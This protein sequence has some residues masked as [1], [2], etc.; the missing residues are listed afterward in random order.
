VDADTGK[1]DNERE[2]IG[3]HCG[4]NEGKKRAIW[5]ETDCVTVEHDAV[6]RTREKERE[7]ERKENINMST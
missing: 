4:A 5:N 3:E 7:K 1:E 6:R 2:S